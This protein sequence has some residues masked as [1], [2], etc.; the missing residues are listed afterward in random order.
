MKLGTVLLLVKFMSL[1]SRHFLRFV[2]AKLIQNLS[3][4][5][6]QLMD[7]RKISF[8]FPRVILHVEF[9]SGL[10]VS[11]LHH[12]FT[13]VSLFEEKSIFLPRISVKPQQRRIPSYHAITSFLSFVLPLNPSFTQL[14][15]SYL[16]FV[17]C[18]ARSLLGSPSQIK[19][20]SL[21]KLFFVVVVHHHR[22]PK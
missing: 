19:R 12:S 1:P 6:F 20:L 14:L 18:F 13:N 11:S 21:F 9:L 22:I 7:P 15:F 3:A 17:L 4:F 5:I 16:L 8:L 10:F 2:K